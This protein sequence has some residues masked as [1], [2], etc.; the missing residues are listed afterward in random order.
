M[1]TSF[2]SSL[3]SFTNPSATDALDSVSVPHADQHADLNDAM[4]AVQAKLGVGA[5][6]IGVYQDY[7]PSFTGISFSS[8]TARY[9]RVNDMVHV[10]FT[11]ILSGAVTTAIAIDL[12]FNSLL[13]GADLTRYGAC[14]A[15][16]TG[17][18]QYREGQLELVGAYVR[19]Y[20][21]DG[22]GSG[23]RWDAAYPFTWASGDYF[24]FD[25]TYEVA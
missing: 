5:G 15:F 23:N 7:T 10:Y 3:D 6:T 25:L 24:S 22:V 11:G 19:F 13:T 17:S 9:T 4:E 20:G 12:P 18:S 1:A 8:Y 2:P 16:D 21:F 14:A